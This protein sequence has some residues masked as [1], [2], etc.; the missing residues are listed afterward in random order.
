MSNIFSDFFSTG[1]NPKLDEM[2]AKT[3]DMAETVSKKSSEHLELSRKRVELLDT[4]SK[5]SKLYEKYGQLQYC[6]MTGE[7]A[8]EEELKDTAEKIAAAREKAELLSSEI[9]AIKASFAE[10]VQR[11]KE[12]IQKEMEKTSAPKQEADVETT[13]ADENDAQE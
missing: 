11:T 6:I 8:D 7:A 2:L 12:T 13:V 3:R 1:N 4:K 9:E 10:T 5:L